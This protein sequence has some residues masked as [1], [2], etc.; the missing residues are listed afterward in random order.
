MQPSFKLGM[1]GIP[2]YSAKKVH[3]KIFET[4]QDLADRGF[5]EEDVAASLNR[6][7]NKMK[8]APVEAG[9][10]GVNLLESLAGK[11]VWERDLM[12]A[13]RW[14]VHAKELEAQVFGH[15]EVRLLLLRETVK[16]VPG[17]ARGVDGVSFGD[18]TEL[19]S[20][21]CCTQEETGL[22]VKLVL[23]KLLNNPH[24]VN[25]TMV[26]SPKA[27]EEK[28]K[29]EEEALDK[30]KAMY[31]AG[32]DAAIGLVAD[33]ANLTSWQTTPDSPEAE[34]AVP[35]LS[36]ED[37]EHGL[38][39]WSR[40]GEITEPYP[41]TTVLELEEQTSGLLYA[42]LGIDLGS[43]VP[44]NDVKLLPLLTFAFNTFAFKG[45]TKR[46]RERDEFTNTCGIEYQIVTRPRIGAPDFPVFYLLIEGISTAE[47]TPHLLKLM[48]MALLN[49][50]LDSAEAEDAMRRHIDS[51]IRQMQ[52][53]FQENALSWVKRHTG[54][55]M[56]AT[57]YLHS[58]LEVTRH[59]GIPH[60]RP[61][62]RAD[63]SISS[64]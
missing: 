54:A 62:R 35:V 26:S 23:E 29:A 49:I 16:K 13:M 57:G 11:W 18:A 44:P 37:V 41:G 25:V 36:L 59:Q 33:V 3:E 43:S 14:D 53:D 21:N 42:N 55:M 56:T 2:D 45:S 46:E 17:E 52:S 24:Y 8:R 5:E 39:L 47:Q 28:V 50:E 9:V 10:W 4:L 20:S 12:E 32:S 15:S 64:M 7:K 1:S 51:T 60:P 48:R 30:I 22:L 31:P 34:A 40:A 58:Q 6:I 63:V 61:G 38:P 19:V 27:A